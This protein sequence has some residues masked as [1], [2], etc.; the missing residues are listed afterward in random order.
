VTLEEPR[1]SKR[2][3]F[4]GR[5]DAVPSE[6]C[7]NYQGTHARPF[8]DRCGRVTY[9]ERSPDCVAKVVL[10]EASKILSAA[11]AFFV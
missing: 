2:A 5:E 6:N 1:V 4:E 11:G 8:Y 9:W 7:A 10:Q 3:A